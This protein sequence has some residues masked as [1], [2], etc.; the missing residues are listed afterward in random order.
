VTMYYLAGTSKVAG[1]ARGCPGHLQRIESLSQ[2]WRDKSQRL[3]FVSVLPGS[4][5]PGV[6]DYLFAREYSLGVLITA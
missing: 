3:R 4:L 1:L 6:I 2:T 5:R